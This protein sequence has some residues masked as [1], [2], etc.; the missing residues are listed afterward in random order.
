MYVKSP[1]CPECGTR[2]I[3][4]GGLWEVGTVRLRCTGCGHMFLP[5]GSPRSRTV[6]AI[7]NANVSIE[8]WEP[9]E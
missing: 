3:V 2:F 7:T 4:D 9:D 5:P 8:V 1:A 6:E